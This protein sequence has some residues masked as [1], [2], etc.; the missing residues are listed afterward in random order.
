MKCENNFCIYENNGLCI[1]DN[2]ELDFQGQCKECIYV[3]I[4][5]EKL[6]YLKNEKRI[7]LKVL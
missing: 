2:V 5:K 4:E 7:I 1:L 6:N 3:D